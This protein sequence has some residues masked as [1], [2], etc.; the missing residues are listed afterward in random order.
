MMPVTFLIH[1]TEKIAE[2]KARIELATPSL[3]KTC[4][5]N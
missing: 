4:S 2:P 3:R 1:G 5:T